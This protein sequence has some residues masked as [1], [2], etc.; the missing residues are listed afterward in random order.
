[1]RT[2]QRNE[3]QKAHVRNRVKRAATVIRQLWFPTHRKK[4]VQEELGEEIMA[5]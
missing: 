3:G 4:K 1:M 5:F 2:L